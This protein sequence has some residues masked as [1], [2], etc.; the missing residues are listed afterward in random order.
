MIYVN[1]RISFFLAGLLEKVAVLFWKN[2]EAPSNKKWDYSPKPPAF[3]RQVLHAWRISSFCRSYSFLILWIISVLPEDMA[4]QQERQVLLF[5]N[6]HLIVFSTS[7]WQI[8]HSSGI[9]F[10]LLGPFASR[11]WDFFLLYHKNGQ[12]ARKIRYLYR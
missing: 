5:N 8:A 4:K 11:L 3:S 1:G 6:G 2:R 12:N 7:F 9:A 10:S